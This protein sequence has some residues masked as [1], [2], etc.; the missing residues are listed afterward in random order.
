[1]LKYIGI[2]S[3]FIIL[4][5]FFPISFYFNI[6]SIKF[7]ENDSLTIEVG[8]ITVYKDVDDDKWY[9][10][11]DNL[12]IK[13]EHYYVIEEI[14][15]GEIYRN[16]NI[17]YVNIQ[18]KKY[19]NKT[20]NE[21]VF[22]Y[23]NT[24]EIGF[25]EDGN[26]TFMVYI[27]GELYPEIKN[28]IVEN[29]IGLSFLAY[30]YIEWNGKEWIARIVLHSN[31]G[32]KGVHWGNI[33]RTKEGFEINIKIDEWTGTPQKHTSI[34]GEYDYILGILPE[35]EYWLCIYVNDDLHT[36]V[37]FEIKR[38]F[39][40]YIPFTYTTIETYTYEYPTETIIITETRTFSS[41]LITTT[42]NV[43]ETSKTTILETKTI[44]KSEV[45]STMPA[46]PKTSSIQ[47]FKETKKEGI[48]SWIVPSTLFIIVILITFL[49]YYILFKRR[50]I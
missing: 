14:D 9:A 41:K 18:I 17:F 24:Y 26:Y 10:S 8:N 19:R 6:I 47:T 11:I 49:L 37:P 20:L 3:L 25:L 48:E 31:M 27:N 22:G 1:M 44:Q 46:F 4:L 13:N 16:G 7:N 33:E 40:T 12:F 45:T 5:L 29:E 39:T 42:I 28:F 21:D 35:G 30:P 32:P 43:K 38:V 15:W 34:Y 36:Y 50:E 23:C 2:P